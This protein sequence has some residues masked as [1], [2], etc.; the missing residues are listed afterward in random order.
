MGKNFDMPDD[1]KERI[2]NKFQMQ[3]DKMIDESGSA[4]EFIDKAEEQ[5]AN[6]RIEREPDGVA[7]MDASDEQ[8]YID[9]RAKYEKV[10]DD[11]VSGRGDSDKLL[12]Q[13]TKMESDF[14][15]LASDMSPVAKID[16][17][18][19]EQAVSIAEV[20][21]KG[22][23]EQA[24]AIYYKTPSDKK[25]ATEKVV[26]ESFGSAEPDLAKVSNGIL[27]FLKSITNPALTYKEACKKEAEAID[28]DKEE[29]IY[30]KQDSYESGGKTVK[31]TKAMQHLDW[32]SVA[33]DSNKSQLHNL[34][35]LRMFIS[36]QIY[37]YFGGW[38][39]ITNI[40]V[41]SQQL[42]I[43]NVCY[44]PMIDEK[45]VSNPSTFPLDSISYIKNGFIAPLF[46]WKFLK[47][48]SRLTVLDI[49]DTAFYLQDVASDIGVGRRAGLSTIFS[50]VPSLEIFIL[51]GEKVAVDEQNTEQGRKVKEKIAKHKHFF[52]FSDGY[53]L[54]G[55][56]V[57]NGIQGW[58]VNNLKNYATNRGSRGILM[59]SG[60]IL[61]RTAVVGAFGAVNLATH[62][63]GGAFT[64]L[65]ECYKDATTPVTKDDFT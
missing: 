9:V 3:I 55:Y 8:S 28:L 50:A 39:R 56:K 43:N 46:N 22:N 47:K 42:I 7:V 54:N 23:K 5:T 58:A 38:S 33:S 21:L 10:L 37:D 63:V 18:Q 4:A 29:P 15:E 31:F 2:M 49:D 1:V 60:G 53:K 40:V 41:R 19:P 30:Y 44:S 13:I 11:Y 24:D 36:R 6:S 48:M 59:F 57:T 12:N 17:L 65:K 51:G 34:E 27:D 14:P 32:G 16:N 62:L 26:Q 61:G 52:N 64:F 20:E 45:Y 35:T 25:P